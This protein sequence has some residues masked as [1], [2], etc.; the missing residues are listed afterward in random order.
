LDYSTRMRAAYLR[1]IYRIDQIRF[2]IFR[3]RWG[4]ALQIT[5]E[6]SP[7]LRYT[8]L[9]IEP[10]GQLRIAPGFFTERQPG[11][12]IW[13]MEGASVEL[14]ERAWLRSEYAS[15]LVTA[16]PGARISVARDALLNG[17]MLHSKGSITIGHESRLAFGTRIFDADLHD[18]DSE[19]PEGISPVTIGDRVWIGS[20]TVVLRGVTIGDDVVVG[21]GSIVTKDIP[22]RTLALG[23]PAKPIRDLAIRT[24]CQ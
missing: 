19:T 18:L 21:A 16:F 9:R 20:D 13:I 5:G 1:T 22:S 3:R 6:C 11:N 12:R 15:N 10:G 2:E 17:T 7:N 24:D 8:H 14:G 23:A 4:P